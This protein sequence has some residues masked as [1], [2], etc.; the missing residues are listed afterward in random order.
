MAVS[1]TLTVLL[2]DRVAGQLVRE[3][4]KHTFTYDPAYAAAPDATPLSLSMPLAVAEHRDSAVLPFLLGLLPDNDAVLRRWGREFGVRPSNPFGLLAHVG[5]DCAG[6]VQLVRPERVDHLDPGDVAWLEDEQVAARIRRLRLDPTAW[7]LTGSQGQFSLAGAQAKTALHRDRGRWGVPS[8]RVPTTHILK[9][10]ISGLDDHDLNE[11]LCLDLA[12]RLGLTAAQSRIVQVA[13][14]RAVAVTRYDRIRDASGAWIR[15]HQEDMCQALGVPPSR[16]YQ[17]DRGPSAEQIAAQL[18]TTAPHG[19]AD[20]AVAAFVDALALNWIIAG[21]DAHAKNYSLLLS[22][23]AVRL[24]PLYDVAS[25]LPYGDPDAGGTG[26]SGGDVDLHDLHDLRSAMRI[27][28]EYALSYIGRD[29]WS[30]LA[31]SVGLDPDTVLTR[32]TELAE[33][34]PVALAAACA[35]LDVD[36]ESTSLPGRLLAA[37]SARA[38]L[39]AARVRPPSPHVLPPRDGRIHASVPHVPAHVDTARRPASSWTAELAARLYANL[40]GPQRLVLR[41]LVQRGGALTAEELRELL[42]RGSFRG[43]TGPVTK[44]LDRLTRSGLLPPGLPRPLR[45]RYGDDQLGY[46]RL[47]ALEIPREALP[48]WTEALGDLPAAASRDGRDS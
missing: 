38:E 34:T 5:E 2:Y 31:A 39:C 14:V 45:S 37:V 21:T 10:A 40:S 30:R 1:Q 33:R 24:A 29:N 44:T 12:R 27:G 4:G 46:R 11:H 41:A 19:G 32:V 36:G 25:V 6:A 15:V 13:D 7:Q 43:L 35:A 26:G 23:R 17:A 9:P 28:G 18:R 16:K 3:R 22:G 8:G 20:S 47:D 48:A 42:D